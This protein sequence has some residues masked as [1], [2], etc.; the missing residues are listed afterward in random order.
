[1]SLGH[2][3]QAPYSD[4]SIMTRLKKKERVSL[5]VHMLAGTLEDLWSVMAAMSTGLHSYSVAKSRCRGHRSYSTHDEGF[6][7]SFS[8]RISTFRAT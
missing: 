6:N 3:F 8:Q 7:R 1:M 5:D 4:N 2:E